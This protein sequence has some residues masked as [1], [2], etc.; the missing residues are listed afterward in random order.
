[1]PLT[2]QYFFKYNSS[3]TSR[4]TALLQETCVQSGKQWPMV[5][6]RQRLSIIFMRSLHDV[7][8]M[9]VGHVCL[10]VHTIQLENRWTDL[11]VVLHGRYAICI[12]PKIELSNFLQSVIPIW[13]T[14]ELVRWDRH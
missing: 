11:D 5:D 8:K 4:H 10:S 1:M 2:V 6:F 9:N 3:V 14:N 12:C 7:H 13:R